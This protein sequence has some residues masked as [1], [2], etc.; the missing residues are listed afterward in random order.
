CHCG[1][2]TDQS[3]CS[4]FRRALEDRVCESDEL[5]MM[6]RTASAIAHEL[7]EETN[8]ALRSASTRYGI[9]PT[10][11]VTMHRPVAIASRTLTGVLSIRA[12]L[13]NTS[14]SASFAGTSSL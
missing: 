8:N 7:S 12:V 10:S 9:P 6:R 2:I 3:I 14:A 5:L 1:R 4:A 11:V 13:R